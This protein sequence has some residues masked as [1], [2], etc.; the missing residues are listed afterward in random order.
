RHVA[1]NQEISAGPLSTI[2]FEN[3]SVYHGYSIIP[4]PGRQSR[5]DYRCIFGHRQRMCGDAG[6]GK[7]STGYNWTQ[8]RGAER[9]RWVMHEAGLAQDKILQVAGDLS[10]D[11]DCK[12]IVDST[13]S[14]FGRIDI[15]VNNAGIL[16][17][18]PLEP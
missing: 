4:F 6:A 8:C 17:P 13:V 2:I 3:L 7:V 1:S 18:G 16:V 9:D 12:R 14:K 10:N 5:S 11:E 15:L